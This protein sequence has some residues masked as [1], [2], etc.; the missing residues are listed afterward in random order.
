MYAKIMKQLENEFLRLPVQ[1]FPDELEDLARKVEGKFEEI[2]K[3]PSKVIYKNPEIMVPVPKLILD[4]QQNMATM[5]ERMPNQE[6]KS[7]RRIEIEKLNYEN[8]VI[9]MIIDYALRCV[10]LNF[11]LPYTE[12]EKRKIAVLE[13]RLKK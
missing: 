9:Y 12:E 5:M 13:N 11:V 10:I 3:N 2:T 8:I 1:F 7:N 6:E 4:R